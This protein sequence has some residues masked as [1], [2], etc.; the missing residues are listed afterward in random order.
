[1]EALDSDDVQRN[2]KGEIALHGKT[3]A[4]WTTAIPGAPLR[5]GG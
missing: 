4:Y 1:M 2:D 3:C 5:Q